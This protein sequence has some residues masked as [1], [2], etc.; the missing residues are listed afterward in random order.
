MFGPFV[1]LYFNTSTLFLFCILRATICACILIV[2]PSYMYMVWPGLNV[3]AVFPCGVRVWELF[4]FDTSLSHS[5]SQSAS[6]PV[7]QLVS[8]CTHT[9]VVSV[10]NH[11][12]NHVYNHVYTLY[13]Y[14]VMQWGM[15]RCY[16]VCVVYLT[17]AAA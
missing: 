8:V 16:S 2:K 4:S 6:Q 1:C 9:I 17:M 13:C 7:S 10:Y 11:V 15:S 5:V 14:C 3:A 12:C